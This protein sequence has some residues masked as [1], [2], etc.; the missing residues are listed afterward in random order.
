MA[1]GTLS[2]TGTF[3]ITATVVDALGQSSTQHLSVR[4]VPA[5]VPEINPET[6]SQSCGGCSGS[7]GTGIQALGLAALALL[8]RARRKK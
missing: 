6:E 2:A 7:G 5:R 3:A 1:S 4:V 8:R